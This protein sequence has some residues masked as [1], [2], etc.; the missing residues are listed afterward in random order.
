M[1]NSQ[2]YDSVVAA[3]QRSLNTIHE[4]GGRDRDRDRDHGHDHDHGHGDDRG[5]DCGYGCDHDGGRGRDPGDC[6]SGH[7]RNHPECGDYVRVRYD[8]GCHGY[9]HIVCVHDQADGDHDVHG[10]GYH[11]Y[12]CLDERVSLGNLAPLTV[13]TGL[14]VEPKFEWQCPDHEVPILSYL[15][16]Q[17]S[18]RLDVSS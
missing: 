14:E 2:G 4:S 3:F 6:G 13:E 8:H 11:V 9:S 7:G 10:R 12:D 17:D 5:D 15:R 1:L 18:E 16:T